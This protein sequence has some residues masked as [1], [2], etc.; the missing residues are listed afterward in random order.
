M[1]WEVRRESLCGW[2]ARADLSVRAVQTENRLSH[3]ASMV[4]VARTVP[5]R[6][7]LMLASIASPDS[8]L[9]PNG[10]HE[11]K[12][13]QASAQTREERPMP[14]TAIYEQQHRSSGWRQAACG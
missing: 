4:R 9:R 13:G 1:L 11:E 2:R 7:A 10:R 8:H 14:A 3:C 12:S 5:V 6:P